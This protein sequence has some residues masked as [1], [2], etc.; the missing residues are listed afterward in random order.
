MGLKT[1]TACLGYQQITDLD[2]ASS[3]TVPANATYAIII[4]Q[5]AEA[6]WRDDGTAPDGTT[7]MPLA[8]G[9]A[10]LYDGDLH[11]IQFFSATGG[12]NVSYYQ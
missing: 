2:P 3:L 1:T 9:V 5:A 8:T 4:A 7:G 11:K 10:L 12:I 6:R